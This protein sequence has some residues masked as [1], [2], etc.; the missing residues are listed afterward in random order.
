MNETN[1]INIKEKEEEELY[2]IIS[3][4]LFELCREK[5]LDPIYFLSSKMLELTGIDIKTMNLNINSKSSA[6]DKLMLTTI[7]KMCE[8]KKF[9]ETYNIIKNISKSKISN[10]ESS[11]YLVEKKSDSKY[12]Y[13]AKIISKN[14]NIHISETNKEKLIL[15]DHKNLAKI[16]EIEEDD[17][18]FYFVYEYCKYGNLKKYLEDNAR[19]IDADFLLDIFKQVISG[20]AYLNEN[21]IIYGSIK[22]ENILIHDIDDIDD[23]SV[24]SKKSSEKI[25]KFVSLKLAD[26]GKN[27]VINNKNIGE[28]SAKQLVYLS[29]E[30]IS[31]NP[32]P[33]SDVWSLGILF[34]YLYSGKYPFKID[35]DVSNLIIDIIN[36]EIDFSC[37]KIQRIKELL[38]VML[39]KNHLY[40]IDAF[41]L[42]D[43]ELFKNSLNDSVD[44]N[45]NK[46]KFVEIL[47]NIK[48][49]NKNDLSEIVLNFILSNRLY[50]DKNF[51]MNKL[52]Q[53]IDINNDGSI[54]SEELLS[55]YI[56]YY[57]GTSEEKKTKIKE[58][59]NKLDI[60][61][62]GRIDY[63]EFILLSQ[64]MTEEEMDNSLKEAFNFLDV[65]KSGF[66]DMKDLMKI[67]KKENLDLNTI[68]EMI[69]DLDSNFD[70]KLSFEEFKGII[71][72]IK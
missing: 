60:N 23:M 35:Q 36:T 5:P 2:N 72:K 50:N 63:S 4:S 45:E 14:S 70:S 58:L 47:E 40:R 44:M 29:P 37:I 20:I 54:S 12:K 42:M 18:Y 64:K 10:V 55:N 46:I 32:N 41:T 53:Q 49:Q 65:T 21:N 69:N 62:N 30:E 7:K 24:N 39:I 3:S 6:K 48:D 33:K 59:M 9:H 61:Q 15:I 57:P 25:A 52:F 17:K 51:E 16:V 8:G 26:V 28:L 66:I 22:L 71:T 27:F 68:Q 34:Y 38:K 67:F 56:N 11:I 31:G 43:N 13:C 1:C 19:G